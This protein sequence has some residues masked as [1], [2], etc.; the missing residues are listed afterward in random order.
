M[1]QAMK[2]AVNP[3]WKLLIADM[4]GSVLEILRHADLPGD[5]FMLKDASLSTEEYFRLWHGIEQAMG[6]E[7]LPLLVGQAISAE[8]FDPPIFAAFCSANLRGAVQRLN[9]YKKLI[10]PMKLSLQQKPETSCISIQ[11]LDY[12]EPL[13]R[14]IVL[15]E[16]VFLTKLARMGTRQQIS[17]ESVTVQQS[18][19]NQQALASF[20]E[21][22][23][24][25]G[26]SDSI[27]FSTASM[28]CPFMTENQVMWQFFEPELQKRLADIEAEASMENR[29]ASTLR[30]LLP[31]GQSSIE[32]VAAKLAL[33]KRTLQRRLNSEQTHFQAVLQQ[34]REALAH[35]YLTHSGLSSGEISFLLGFLDTNSFYRAFQQWT[36]S[37][38]ESYRLR[39]QSNA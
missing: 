36:D 7:N 25:T 22:D 12:Q 35:H 3:N 34:T 30:E 16:L 23:I 6:A 39:H 37:T 29:V 38:P 21:C 10:G 2:F 19:A 13:P 31:A 32:Q 28:D 27:V 20:F 5:L 18:V 14:S 33:S 9:Q 15:T 24:S 8:V 26:D 17:P 11:C 4:G 1:K